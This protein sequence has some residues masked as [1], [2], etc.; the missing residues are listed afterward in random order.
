M[1]SVTRWSPEDSV[2]TLKSFY[3]LYHLEVL[4]YN[5]TWIPSGA[6]KEWFVE[7][8]KAFDWYTNVSGVREAA[9]QE[10]K[11]KPKV[12]KK[13]KPKPKSPFQDETK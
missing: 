2:D 5:P 6:S 10:Y 4:G 12:V 13:R 9:I 8:L 1:E 3:C 11:K 7:Q